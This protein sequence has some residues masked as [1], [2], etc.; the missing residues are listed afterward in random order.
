MRGYQVDAL[1]F[2]VKSSSYGDFSLCMNRAVRAFSRNE[3]HTLSISTQDGPRML[4][5]SEL[6]SASAQGR[7]LVFRLSSG[8]TLSAHMPLA[9]LERQLSANEAP[10]LRISPSC[11]ANMSHIHRLS[12]SDLLMDDGS[13]L[14]ISHGRKAAALSSIASYLGGGA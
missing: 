3:Q 2:V 5:I 14:R 4:A 1:G 10:V 13:V 11:L 7:D 8:E 12:G 9:D 6:V